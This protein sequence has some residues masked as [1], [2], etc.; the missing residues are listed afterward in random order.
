MPPG[1]PMLWDQHF[2]HNHC[3]TFLVLEGSAI[4]GNE[5]GKLFTLKPGDLCQCPVH[6]HHMLTVK[7]DSFIAAICNPP[8]YQMKINQMKAEP[9]SAGKD[10]KY[11]P[12]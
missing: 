5:N 3:E 8:D 9:L 6:A 1:K 12:R 4:V 7:E 10:G 11:K 2:H